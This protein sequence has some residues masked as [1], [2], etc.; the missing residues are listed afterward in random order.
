LTII[1]RNNV[2]PI[3]IA[4]EAAP[5]FIP[6]YNALYAALSGIAGRFPYGAGILPHSGRREVSFRGCQ[7]RQ[8]FVIRRHTSRFNAK[9]VLHGSAD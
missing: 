5:F 8:F 4:G 1:I 6:F 3:I 9:G 7:P 2:S